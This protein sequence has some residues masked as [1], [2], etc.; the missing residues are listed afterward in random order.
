LSTI[1][2]NWGF[3][4]RAVKELAA[5]EE[6]EVGYTKT[7]KSTLQEAERLKSIYDESLKEFLS[8]SRKSANVIDQNK[9]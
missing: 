2:E 1:I 9:G 4:P 7:S 3:L 5:I 6:D 8:S